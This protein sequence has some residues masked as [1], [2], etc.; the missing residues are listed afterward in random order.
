MPPKPSNL[1]TPAN[2]SSDNKGNF[3]WGF[4][5]T[6][7]FVFDPEANTLTVT[8]EEE[9]LPEPTYDGMTLFFD[10]TN[11]NWNEVY[12]YCWNNGGG[13]NHSWSGEPAVKVEGTENLWMY[14]VVGKTY[15]MVIFN[16]NNNGSQTGDL[17]A[18]HGHVYTNDGN[19]TAHV[20]DA[21]ATTEVAVHADFN[22]KVHADGTHFSGD[23]TT[24]NANFKLTVTAA[25]GHEVF[26]RVF[27]PAAASYA[28][29]PAS[30]FAGYKAVEGG[31][32]TIPVGEG[33]LGLSTRVHGVLSTPT[34]YSFAVTNNDTPTGV[35]GI[36]VENNAT[37]VYYNLQGVRVANPEAGHVYIRVA[38]GTSAKVRF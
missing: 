4:A 5:C 28:A 8:T 36:E 29:A 25:E 35:E 13:E 33:S 38:N 3:V 12:A 16:N 27:A 20:F 10:N 11:S 24:D 19:H 6:A 37:A 21:P 34:M 2:A 14:K 32:I 1:A 26:Y 23:V 31:E 18:V 30:T 22:G 7:T 17:Q 9:I 15:D